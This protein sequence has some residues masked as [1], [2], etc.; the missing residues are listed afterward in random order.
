MKLGNTKVNVYWS[1]KHDCKVIKTGSGG[2][3]F[4][5]VQ[6]VE[7]QEV[8]STYGYDSLQKVGEME[9]TVLPAVSMRD[10]FDGYEI[11]L[12]AEYQ[13][14][15]CEPVDE[16]DEEAD[17]HFWTLYGHLPTG[18]VEAISDVCS[19]DQA[20]RLYQLIDP[21]EQLPLLVEGPDIDPLNE[22]EAA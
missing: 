1:Q 20:V 12:V 11:K 6:N 18:G 21:L 9:L 19:R 8:F 13:F 5:Y 17:K 22:K 4:G 3:R 14:G 2:D 15:H 7:T 10:G 16:F